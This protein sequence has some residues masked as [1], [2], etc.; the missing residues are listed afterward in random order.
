MN[1]FAPRPFEWFLLVETLLYSIGIVWFI[2]GMR[3]RSGAALVRPF[4]SVVVAA[5]NEEAQIVD[6]LSGLAE[7]DY[8]DYEVVVVDDGSTDSTA[9]LIAGWV[10]KDPRF[11]IVELSGGG[12]K[13]AALTAAI[14]EATG[15]VIATTDADCAVGRGWLSGL[16]AYLEDGVGM[17]IGFSQIGMSGEKLGVRGGYEAVDFLN[18]MACIWGSSGWRHPMA[19]SG[20]NLLFRRAAYEEV[21]GYEKV[22]HRISGDDVLLMQMIRT[23]TQWR[24]AF[25]SEAD[26]FTVHPPSSSWKSLLNQRARWASNAPLMA[27]MDPLFYGYMLITYGLSWCVIL[28]PLLVLAG[29]VQPFLMA[30]VLGVKWTGES[31]F[32]LRANTLGQRYDLGMFLPL[33]MLL[34]PLHVAL[35]GGLGALGVF[36]WKG[37]RHRW[38]K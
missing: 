29:W 32:F 10:E 5:R 3:R 13:K 17:V 8:P 37:K 31:F 19:A 12:S 36:S 20:Q 15:E 9:V 27:Q 16:A 38:G 11:K 1:W 23:A 21:G 2:C 24:I 18:L 34:Q 30:A 22:M 7:Q 28:S 6:C 26:S 4:I 33:Y 25:A 14:K 35:V